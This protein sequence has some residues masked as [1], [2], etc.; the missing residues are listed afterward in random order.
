LSGK[1]ATPLHLE[2]HASRRMAAWLLLVHAVGIL[3]L[4]FAALPLPATLAV[5]AGIL[6]SL[7]WHWPRHASRTA[8][9]CIRTLTWNADGSCHMQ[10]QDGAACL[11]TL[12]RQAFVQPWLVILQLREA[13][14]LCRHLV[15][16][17]DMLEP[18]SFRHLRVRLKLEL[19][20]ANES[21]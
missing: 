21:H 19:G 12:R 15:I 14:Y 2:L 20:Q 4:P 11:V 18:A 6:V 13:G 9:A 17:P 7:V 8:P 1:Y 3:V 5:A 16:V 10:R